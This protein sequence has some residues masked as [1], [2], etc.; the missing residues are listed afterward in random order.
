MAYTTEEARQ[1]LLDDLARAIHEIGVALAALGE[2]YE[3]LDE[4]TADRLEE[5]LFRPTQLLYGRAKRTHS[6][7]AERHGL[8]P[9][10]LPAP[11][12]PPGRDARSFIEA[13]ADAAEAAD[14]L[15]A[16]LQDS[17]LP[18]EVGD[19]PLRAGL[20]EAREAVGPLP[21]RA[22]ALMRVLGR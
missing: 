19:P 12:A 5:E 14:Q 21:G 8:P 1:Q 10:A 17:M 16:E 2:A 22:Q 11:P 6:G 15:L 3:R 18:V 7:F 13:A 20:A 9:R 4:R